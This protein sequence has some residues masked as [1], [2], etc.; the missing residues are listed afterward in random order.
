MQVAVAQL[1]RA[2][3][4]SPLL[5][6]ARSLRRRVA[7]HAARANHRS[8]PGAD[9]SSRFGDRSGWQPSAAGEAVDHSPSSLPCTPARKPRSVLSFSPRTLARLVPARALA[10]RH[11]ALVAAARTGDVARLRELLMAD[12]SGNS[13][14]VVDSQRMPSLGRVSQR[15][16]QSGSVAPLRVRDLTPSPLAGG[17]NVR[18]GLSDSRTAPA[19]PDSASARPLL[20]AAIEGFSEHG[21]VDSM[22]SAVR[23]LLDAGAPARKRDAR[24]WSSVSL[25]VHALPIHA[26]AAAL[27]VL[28]PSLAQLSGIGSSSGLEDTPPGPLL[29]A[30]GRWVA[31]SGD[32]SR[33]ADQLRGSGFGLPAIAAFE[34]L[35]LAAGAPSA[36]LRDLAE[37]GSQPASRWCSAVVWALDVQLGPVCATGIHAA[38][39]DHTALHLACLAAVRGWS[40]SGPSTPADPA[41]AVSVA[42][43]LLAS[44]AAACGGLHALNARDAAGAAPLDLLWRAAVE[45]RVPLAATGALCALADVLIDAGA[46]LCSAS[47]S[48]VPTGV[49]DEAEEPEAARRLRALLV[50]REALQSMAV[51]HRLLSSPAVRRRLGRVPPP[52]AAPF[53]TPPLPPAAGEPRSGRSG[54]GSGAGSAPHHMAPH[55][56]SGAR[57]PSL[58]KVS[59][60]DEMRK[61]AAM[62]AAARLGEAVRGMTTGRAARRA[63]DV[64]DKPAAVRGR[65]RLELTPA[66]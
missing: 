23:L 52:T 4:L 11:D 20:H 22:C 1:W 63:E 66:E 57:G 37:A 28:L 45:A 54:A 34:L 39:G 5:R 55:R 65:R 59:S 32:W 30:L 27:E 17:D 3:D 16:G 13:D 43:R 50:R 60:A 61:L 21:S 31:E 14:V 53:A 18:T 51:A 58:E 56:A 2:L 38:D 8:S 49:D 25:A 6:E 48:N 42:E 12:S 19:P 10:P 40:S 9:P 62:A 64:A 35:K 46:Q 15:L 7:S 36:H 41:P 33:V 44:D 24:G 29:W 47:A 26:C